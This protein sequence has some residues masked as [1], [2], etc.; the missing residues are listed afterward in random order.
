MRIKVPHQLLDLTRQILKIG[1]E[2]PAS[3]Y[4]GGGGFP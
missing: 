4:G 1:K 2:G 3:P